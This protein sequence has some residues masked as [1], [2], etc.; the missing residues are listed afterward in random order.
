M[1]KLICRVGFILTCAVYLVSLFVR[2]PA[3]YPDPAPGLLAAAQHVNGISPSWDVI[4]SFDVCEEGREIFYRITWWPPGYQAFPWL[5]MRFAG[6]SL[7]YSVKT[8]TWVLLL[9]GFWGWW[10]YF[11][12]VLP[13]SLA[14]GAIT[15]IALWR[16][17]NNWIDYYDGGELLLFAFSPWVV[18]LSGIT[19]LSHDRE[20]VFFKLISSLLAG[21]IVGLL[22]FL[23][24]SAIA[25][26]AGISL[27]V[28]SASLKYGKLSAL[29]RLFFFALG[30]AIP[31][32]T[33]YFGILQHGDS[34]DKPAI[35]GGWNLYQ[36]LWHWICWPLVFGDWDALGR[37]L[38]LDDNAE[39]K[40]L[41]KFW[42]LGAMWI[43]SLS[44]MLWAVFSAWSKKKYRR[45]K[46][47]SQLS[48]ES[49]F[50]LQVG[51]WCLLAM[52]M[53]VSVLGMQGAALAWEVRYY[54]IP[55]LIL[56]PFVILCL[57]FLLVQRN[58]RVRFN[59]I[60]SIPSIILMGIGTLYG[61][62]SSLNKTFLTAYS[63]AYVRN[64]S[65]GY[66]VSISAKST[67]LDDVC[68]VVRSL[69]VM[70][71]NDVFVVESEVISLLIPD[72]PVI[73]W[74]N[75]RSVLE[76]KDWE[77]PIKSAI[78]LVR[79]NAPRALMN[80]SSFYHFH[81]WKIRVLYENP[82]WQVLRLES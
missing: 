1:I 44:V 73:N 49:F 77:K 16:F 43:L 14:L 8:S 47:L 63:E 76:C 10:L 35:T 37:Y 17:V 61:A 80:E 72:L 4:R 79:K 9:C 19:Q 52:L 34:P 59:K 2:T 68:N 46:V 64:I 5:F 6:L 42:T 58:A 51:V 54:R 18:L 27:A 29:A 69:S 40:D 45:K 41:L 50:Y 39:D 60:L 70:Y 66:R 21:F 31:I 11:K 48:Q 71:R 65:N 56:F 20:R 24:Y 26:A 82:D 38:I 7:G 15:T 23:K 74:E 75:F 67:R 30:T 78:V 33:T 81:D 55:C 28:F 32:T 57:K 3:V 62:V 12:R 22:V 53:L 25:I 13:A 36:V